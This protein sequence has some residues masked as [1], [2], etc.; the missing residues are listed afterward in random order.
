MDLEDRETPYL[1]DLIKCQ[2]IEK[3]ASTTPGFKYVHLNV[4]QDK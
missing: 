3:Y 1:C 2:K 4:M